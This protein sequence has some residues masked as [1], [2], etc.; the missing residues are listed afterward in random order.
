VSRTVVLDADV[1]VSSLLDL[2]DDAFDRLVEA[3]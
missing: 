1:A 3:E 2:P